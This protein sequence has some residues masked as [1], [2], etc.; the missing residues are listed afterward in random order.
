[1]YWTVQGARVVS[2]ILIAALMLMSCTSVKTVRPA[3]IPSSLKEGD[4]VKVV[5]NDGTERE[6][7]IVTVTPEAIVGEDQRIEFADIMRVEKREIDAGKTAALGAGVLAV[8]LAAL[9]FVG[10]AVAMSGWR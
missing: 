8:G 4:T 5:T 9:F 10:L 3:D 7:K 2:I 6:F 1:M